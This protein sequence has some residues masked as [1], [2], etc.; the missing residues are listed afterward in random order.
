MPRMTL[1]SRA[2]GIPDEPTHDVLVVLN[3]YAPYVSGVTEAARV[4][5]EGL[6]QRGHRVLVV[7]GHHD[8][9]TPARERLNG[10]DVL[11][12][13][14]RLRIGK[15]IVS[16]SFV[17]T[18]ARAARRARVVNL[19]LPMLEAG[20]IALAV[21]GTPIVSTYQCDVTLPGGVLDQGQVLA[22]DASHRLALRRSEAV[23]V[24]SADYAQHSKLYAAMDDRMVVIPPPSRLR[25]GGVP[26]FRDGPGLH[27]GFLGR[28]VEEKG[29]EYLV[30]GFRALADP[31]L[32]LLVGGDFA[33][34]AG[35]S[36]VE[37]VRAHIGDDPRVRLLGFL[38]DEALADFFASLDVFVLPSVNSLEAFGIVQAEALMAGVPVIASDRPGV[39]TLVQAT[40]FGTVVPPRDPAAITRALRELPTRKLNRT[41]GAATA[42]GLYS[43]ET[44]ID[45]YEKLLFDIAEHRPVAG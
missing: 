23:A 40:G 2:R 24:S 31:A 39:R 19:H 18:V 12:T 10:V 17:P 26:A 38:P 41:V 3:Y 1:P 13:P 36:V 44:V 43:A 45:R 16:P 28:I 22:L 33:N 6:A 42:R 20:P 4:V 14:V 15:G 35:G 37:R 9:A 27:V 29:L 5:A 34:V 30:D 11:R 7:C 21:R 32:R 25:D 8:P